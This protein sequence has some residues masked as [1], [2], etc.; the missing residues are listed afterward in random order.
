MR[1]LQK[2]I[3]KQLKANNHWIRLFVRILYQ[4]IVTSNHILQNSEDL[5]NDVIVDEG[6]NGF[7]E[8]LGILLQQLRG[9][10]RED[11]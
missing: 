7:Q 3:T 11:L 4:I 2:L 1:R 9:C 5:A 8:I 6:K 10:C